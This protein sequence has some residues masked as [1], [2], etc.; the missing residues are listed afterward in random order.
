MQSS[1]EESY[2]SSLGRAILHCSKNEA[3]ARKSRAWTR[4]P[5]RP[6]KNYVLASPNLGTPPAA[7]VERQ[8]Q[9]F[10]RRLAS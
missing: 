2:H 8:M 7:P 1:L 3:A 6:E 4:D 10:R 5:G 9:I